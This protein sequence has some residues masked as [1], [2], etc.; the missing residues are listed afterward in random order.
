MFTG[1]IEATAILRDRTAQG[2]TV[3]RPKSFD[4]VKIGSSIAVSGVCLTIV[5]LTESL[6]R[7][8]VVA[9]T[10]DRTNLNDRHPGD[11]VNLERAMK[12]DARL[13]GHIVQGHVEGTGRVVSSIPQPL[14]PE[15]ERKKRFVGPNVLSFARGMRKRSTK[16]ENHLWK[17]LRDHQVKNLHF[18]RQHPIG[19]LILDFY[20]H[21]LRLGIEV[22]GG[23]HDSAPQKKNDR[24]RDEVLREEMGVHVLRFTND[25]VLN[26]LDYVVRKIEES[27]P[28]PPSGAPSPRGGGGTGEGESSEGKETKLSIEVPPDLT[29]FIL[30]KGSICLDGVSLT[31][32]SIEKNIITVALVPHT[33]KETTLGSLKKG[34]RVNIETDVLTRAA[35]SKRL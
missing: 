29:P 3:E 4:D 5:D 17:A 2:I 10:W 27:S 14:P 25:E 30:P 34:D 11:R 23:I 9:E 28:T 13:D 20:C 6:M 18:R 8:D 32:A 19:S 21:A 24:L 22:D 12:S 15:E 31:V 26:D 33:L 1:L 16:A 35:L 7:F